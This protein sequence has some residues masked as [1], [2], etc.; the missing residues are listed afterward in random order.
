MGRPCGIPSLHPPMWDP[1]YSQGLL[2]MITAGQSPSRST[3]ITPCGEDGKKRIP[4]EGPFPCP[5]PE[6]QRGLS[7]HF[8][9]LETGHTELLVIVKVGRVARALKGEIAVRT[10][11]H[12]DLGE[13]KDWDMESGRGPHPGRRPHVMLL[14]RAPGNMDGRGEPPRYL[15]GGT[16]KFQQD[17]G[18]GTLHDV[19]VKQERF[20]P[21]VGGGGIE[22]VESSYPET[23][24]GVQGPNTEPALVC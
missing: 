17:Q 4:K 14:R 6:H 16:V 7:A 2:G 13:H 23:V 5:P 10:L 19:E 20:V 1:P 18:V 12:A 11:L 24:Q 9:V 22:L 3:S 21:R 8:I 15:R